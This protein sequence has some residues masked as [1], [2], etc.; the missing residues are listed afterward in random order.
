MHAI[1]VR[2]GAAD[3]PGT[4]MLSD[5]PTPDVLPDDICVRVHAVSVNP[6]DVKVRMATPADG[7][8]RTLGWDAAGVIES[9]GTA[10]S[11]RK[12]GDKVYYAGSI[13]R[14]GTNSELHCVDGRLVG[15]MP[16]S[17]S[18]AD[19]AA[20]PLT[21][22]TAWEAL[23]EHLCIGATPFGLTNLLQRSRTLLIIGGAGGVGSIAIQLARHVPDLKIIATASRDATR[24]WCEKL[25]AHEVIN[26]HDDLGEQFEARV[27][28]QPDYVLINHQPDRYF[29]PV[30]QLMAPLARICSTVGSAEPLDM[31]GLRS[32]A[33]SWSWEAMFARSDFQA[34]DMYTQGRILDLVGE[35]VDDGKLMTTRT[36]DFGN[37]TPENLAQAHQAVESGEMIGKGVLHGIGLEQS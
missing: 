21:T 33:G 6:I 2:P 14:P 8:D 23:F 30:S 36:T 26:H 13:S 4:F 9:V 27:L 35:W 24:Q 10:V 11:D 32:K 1:T 19:A 7:V 16:S 28:P 12:P 25:G 3:A 29:G 34:A 37:L 20:L 15:R 18:F 31:G 17:L 5:R 22:L